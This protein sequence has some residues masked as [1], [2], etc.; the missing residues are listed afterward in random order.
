M[1]S[2]SH[3]GTGNYPKLLDLARKLAVVP[4]IHNK[5]S[6]IEVHRLCDFFGSTIESNT[7]GVVYPQNEEYI[8]T[9]KVM[10]EYRKSLGKK[11]YRSVLFGLLVRFFGLFINSF[12][13]MIVVRYKL[14]NNWLLLKPRINST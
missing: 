1:S 13:K 5:R 4:K 7:S 11:T 10:V 2:H 9:T 3:E 14:I 8:D 6:V 12:R